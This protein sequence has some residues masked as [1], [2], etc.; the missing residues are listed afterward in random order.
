[1]ATSLKRTG[2]D[3]DLKVIYL[4]PNDCDEPCVSAESKACTTLLRSIPEDHVVDFIIWMMHRIFGMQFYRISHNLG[5]VEMRIMKIRKVLLKKDFLAVHEYSEARGIL[6]KGFAK[7]DSMKVVPPPLS[8]DYTPLSDHTDL[9]ESQMSYVIIF[10][11]SNPNDFAIIV[12][13]VSNLHLQSPSQMILPPVHQLP[14]SDKNENTSRTSCNKNG[15]FNKKAVP[16]GKPKLHAPVPTGRQNRP[17]PVPTDRVYSP[18]VTS[19]CWKSTASPMSHLNRPTSSYFQTYTLYVPQVYYNHMQYGGVR[20]ATIVKPSVGYSWKTHRKG[21]YWE[22]SYTDAEDEGLHVQQR[23]DG[24]FISQ[25][26]YVQEILKKFDLESVRTATTPYEAPKPK[27]KNAPDSP[28]N[29]HLYR[30]MIG[31]LMYLTALRPDIMFAVSACSWNQVT[32]T[33]SNLEAVEK[34]FKYLK[35]QPKLG[36]WYP[37]ESPFVLEI[38]LGQIRI[39]NPQLVDVLIDS[40]EGGKGSF[41]WNH[42]SLW[43]I[44]SWRL[45]TLSNVHVLETVSGELLY[46]F[47]DVSY[48]LSVT[49]MERMLKHKLEIDKDVVGND[50]TT[51]EQLIRFIK[52]QIVAT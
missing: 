38:M 40:Q 22:N 6:H 31:S 11:R 29:V 39:G 45:Y 49:L 19:G 37:K 36:L 20:L 10:M 15:Y 14:V 27:S 17:F 13:L 50:L 42:Q 23:P 25:D 52:N 12:I 43:Q 30:S 35:G 2:R 24:M 48:P 8:G 4:P 41:V 1:M 21:L 47:A 34:I 26:K 28:V 7:A 44:R 16:T 46:M 32:P 33:I 9:D 18:S 5:L 3:R 51:A